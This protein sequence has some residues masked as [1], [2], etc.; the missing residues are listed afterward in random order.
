MYNYVKP[1]WF[2][3]VPSILARTSYAALS[4]YEYLKNGLRYRCEFFNILV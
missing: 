4:K 3:F 1:R 2:P